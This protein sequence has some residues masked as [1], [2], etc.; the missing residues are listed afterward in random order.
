MTNQIVKLVCPECQYENDAERIYCHDCG[1]RLDR[2]AV[3][4]RI[5]KKENI[6]QTRKRVKKL[7]DPT[8]AKIRMWFFRSAKLILGAIATAAVIQMILPPDVPAPPE[9]SLGLSQIGLDLENALNRRG[10]TQLQYTDEQ[11]NAHL[12]YLVKTK[13]STLNKPFL[14]FRRALAQFREGACALTAERAIFGF[15]I[16][17]TTN[18]SVGLGEKP[19]ITNHGGSIGR[20]S[21]HP[22]LMQYGDIIFADLWGAL[23][24]ERRLVMKMQ[25][26]EFHDK[27]VTLTAPEPVQ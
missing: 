14:E 6:G 2:S 15:S 5:S 19:L 9:N 3:A 11:V 20:L 22:F 25:S 17:T 8:G 27:S 24:R 16:Y 7:F 12:R 13:Q 18:Y 26:L 1:A 23:D 21:V 4:S 10:P